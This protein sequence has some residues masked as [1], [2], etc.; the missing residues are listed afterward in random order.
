[1]VLMKRKSKA[2]AEPDKDYILQKP[3]KKR[4]FDEEILS[5]SDSEDEFDKAKD[6]E[7]SE[8]EGD[9]ETAQEKRIRL[10]QEYVNRMRDQ[11]I[12]RELDE[13][14]K[15]EVIVHRLRDEQLELAGK[16]KKPIADLI[17][18][19][20]AVEALE[21][22]CKAQKSPI[23]CVC[24]SN[25]KKFVFADDVNEK[26][27]R[28][29]IKYGK[30]QDQKKPTGHS[31]SVL[32]LA[33]SDDFKHL[34]SGSSDGQIL[35]W[36]PE[37]LE[38]ISVL[39][40]HKGAVNGLAIRKGTGEHLYS[41]ASDKTV[42]VWSLVEM[43]YIETLFGHMDSISAIDSLRKERAITAGG[44]D[45]TI[46]IWKIPEESQLVFNAEEG[47]CVDVVCLMNDQ[48]FV[49][50]DDHGTV[51]YWNVQRKKACFSVRAA[52][53]CDEL[54]GNPCWIT[55]I[56][57]VHNSDVFATGSW[58]GTVLL[59]RIDEEK[60]RFEKLLEYQVPGV[61][62]A[63][64]FMKD[65]VKL[66]AG[67]GKETRLGRWKT[68][69]K[70]LV[71][72]VFC[73]MGCC[74]SSDTSS[75]TNPE[76]SERSH[77]LANPISNS[78]PAS[79]AFLREETTNRHSTSLPK[80]DDEQSVLNR[81]LD[82][83]AKNIID[84]SVMEN[85]TIEQNEYMERSKQYQI[86]LQG[87]TMTSRPGKKV[88]G[89]SLPKQIQDMPFEDIASVEKVLSA[90]PISTADENMMVNLTWEL[91]EAVGCIKV[92]KHKDLVESSKPSKNG[93]FISWECP[94]RILNRPPCLS[95]RTVRASGFVVD[96]GSVGNVG[97]F[98][99]AAAS[100]D[101]ATMEIVLLAISAVVV[102]AGF[103][104][105]VSVR[106]IP[107][108]SYDDIM[109]EKRRRLEEDDKS[110]TDKLKEK[111]L[112][113]KKKKAPKDSTEAVVEK[114]MDSE[115][116][117]PNSQSEAIPSSPEQSPVASKKVVK[118][119]SQRLEVAPEP[120]VEVLEQPIIAVSAVT[121]AAPLKS[122]PPSKLDIGEP[123]ARKK[124]V[125]PKIE[126]TVVPEVKESEAQTSLDPTPAS[127]PVDSSSPTPPDP[128][129]PQSAAAL[130][131]KKAKLKKLSGPSEGVVNYAAVLRK[132]PLSDDSIQQLIE[133][134]LNKQQNAT[135]DAE[136]I[137]VSE[138]SAAAAHPAYPSP[139]INTDVVPDRTETHGRTDSI[140]AL[141]KQLEDKEVALTNAEKL[142]KDATETVRKLRNE[143]I[144][145]QS[146]VSTAEKVLRE[147]TQKLQQD[148]TAL[149]KENQKERDRIAA[150]ASNYESRIQQD[151]TI[152]LNE[153]RGQLR[154]LQ[155]N[156]EA[157][158]ALTQQ[159]KENLE[160]VSSEF[161]RV[162][163]AHRVAVDELTKVKQEILKLND[164]L[165]CVSRDGKSKMDA[166]L[167]NHHHE[168]SRV[169]QERD[170]AQ[171]A[172][173]KVEEKLSESQKSGDN[174]A[175]VLADKAEVEAN[176]RSAR[177]EC[178][179]LKQSLRAVE[180]SKTLEVSRL[181]HELGEVNARLIVA[182][183]EAKASEAVKNE[184]TT[185]QSSSS[186]ERI[187]ELEKALEDE[188]TSRLQESQSSERTADELRTK[189]Q[190]AEAKADY[191]SPYDRFRAMSRTK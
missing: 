48:H 170:A 73:V 72:Y 106:L 80:R 16:L 8:E 60:R 126:A 178:E 171:A 27:L 184:D 115:H 119:V 162:G 68:V 164:E 113:K 102:I 135:P 29:I 138:N 161:H 90:M 188:R 43:S 4:N 37:T 124:R 144:A 145:A 98:S 173:Q 10:A 63:L 32:S 51:S 2:S 75:E 152:A 105:F 56:A 46:R 165:A 130:I 93:K 190:Q 168:I 118:A 153:L 179:T 40:G 129:S 148:R 110:R 30:V 142:S 42:K 182:Q 14:S 57:G 5:E 160:E 53:G 55:A 180:E 132:A 62:N 9:E 22:K 87:L 39:R 58:N 149:M 76:Y 151:A 74:Y 134:L 20:G 28:G 47:S 3:A 19:D 104:Y 128:S 107:Q 166:A 147:Q 122:A 21:L 41:A 109:A 181:E 191:V 175:K 89:L 155:R 120:E 23:T 101:I 49:S 141:K 159:H 127:T 84:V 189:L 157:Q 150:E 103:V 88:L 139:K 17:N 117:L 79:S 18:P 121:S 61:V 12:D 137:Q 123:H 172:L 69:P 100:S 71:L 78:I 70:T 163:E 67:V 146:K 187:K 50:G 133:I 34:V 86:K 54:T 35:V 176:L 85:H 186:A 59:W 99:S 116:S 94:T 91:D 25:D 154:D 169:Q 114:D 158:I 11:D 108:D 77:L 112:G 52:H 7:S 24:V 92:E 177:E 82:E 33:L 125:A 45:S 156:Y 97:S 95:F 111:K 131:K 65:G 83:T 183:N 44:R 15:N 136:W 140:P 167:E 96:H 1:M 81:I 6:V 174:S 38:F 143:L 31:A 66:I 185:D 36:N 64:E 26:S 13:V